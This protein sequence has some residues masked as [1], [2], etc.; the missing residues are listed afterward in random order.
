MAYC[1]Y[2]PRLHFPPSGYGP[3]DHARRWPAQL[4]VCRHRA[5]VRPPSR[6]RFFS[7]AVRPERE[8]GRG[9]VRRRCQDLGA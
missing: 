1:T 5:P 8:R 7:S 2:I 4:L 3:R 9:R 6:S